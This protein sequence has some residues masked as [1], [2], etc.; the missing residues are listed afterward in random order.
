MVAYL[1]YVISHRTV[2][3]DEGKVACVAHWS[4]P[5][6]IKE[7]RSFLGLTGYYLRFI[8]HYGI[9]ARPLTNLLKKNGWHWDEQATIAF[10]QLKNA[11]CSAPI[12]AL[13]DFSIELCLETDAS[14]VVV[15]AVL[16]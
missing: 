5:T 16:Q 3:M 11:L 12:L 2:T 1:G 14:R 13:L 15:E 6:W 7:L 8:R 4:T 9:M 10:Q